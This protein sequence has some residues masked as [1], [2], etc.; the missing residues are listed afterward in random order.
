V[1]YVRVGWRGKVPPSF[2]V[3][4]YSRSL[5]NKNVFLLLREWENEG[6]S[7]DDECC[8]VLAHQGSAQYSERAAGIQLQSV[9]KKPI[10]RANF[11]K[12]AN[13]ERARLNKKRRWG[14]EVYE[15]SCCDGRGAPRR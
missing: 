6:G 7:V 9:R 3:L 1:A 12:D 13:Q 2:L 11:P 15:V 5:Q 14:G 10:V 8:V 4:S